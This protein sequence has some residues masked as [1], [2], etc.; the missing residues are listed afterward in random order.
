MPKP[1]LI[2]VT[3][4]PGSGKTTFSKELGNEICMP[5]ISRDQIKE[6]YVH[7]LG[8]R[9]NELPEEA[10]L[11]ATEIFFDTLMGLI[12]NNVSVIAEAAFQHK[13]W[14][15]FL[16]P[17]MVKAQV[18]LLICKVD[19]KI[20]LDRFVRRGL[21]NPLRE[22]F[23][24]DKGVDLARKGI[25]LSVSPYEE[26]RIDVPIFDIDTSGDYKPSIKELGKKI[27]VE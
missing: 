14:S 26:P 21:D 5:V 16:E 20:A 15:T 25:E 3:G 18:C 11:T 7:T 10:N 27:F 17:F 4:R 19:E 23:H 1:H 24:G 22:Y 6:G 12:T 9:H 8:K 13:I 2:I